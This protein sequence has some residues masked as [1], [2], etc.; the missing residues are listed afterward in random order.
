ME[1]ELKCR[2]GG[3]MHQEERQEQFKRVK[4]RLKDLISY[5]S[6]GQLDE[7]VRNYIGFGPNYMYKCD[8]CLRLIKFIP[9]GRKRDF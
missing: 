9:D 7:F 2:C 5:S 6:D 4:D 1:K 3:L 8:S